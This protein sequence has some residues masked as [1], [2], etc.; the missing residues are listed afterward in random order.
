MSPILN[1]KT[2]SYLKHDSQGGHLNYNITFIWPTTVL[3]TSWTRGSHFYSNQASN[4]LAAEPEI[5]NTTEQV[6]I[7]HTRHS[8][9]SHYH[10]RHQGKTY[11]MGF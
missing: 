4:S 3:Q 6:L 7:A 1:K 11:S 2:G 5:S 9:V 10:S 8:A